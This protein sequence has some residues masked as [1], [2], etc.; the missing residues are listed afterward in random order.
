MTTI[1]RAVEVPHP[2]S[3]P[4]ARLIAQRFSLLAEPMRVRLLDRLR[5]GEASVQDLAA[6]LDTSQQNVS[7]HLGLLLVNGLV[8]RTRRGNLACY[9]IADEE[10]FALCELVCGSLARRHAELSELL[11][12]QR[13]V[14]PREA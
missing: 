11:G 1:A 3:E 7:K 8:D 2:L 14:K 5:G 9:A 12:P 4:L 10:V 13:P 6:A